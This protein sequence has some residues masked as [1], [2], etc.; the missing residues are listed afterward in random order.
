MQKLGIYTGIG[1]SNS[2]EERLE[3]IKAAGFQVV[4]LNFEKDMEHTET[5]WENQMRLAQK[6]SLPVEAVHL[7]GTKMT[8]IWKDCEEAEF[9]TVR[10]MDEIKAM[11]EVGVSTGVAH[12]TWGFNK[13][14]D[15][16]EGA[17]KRFERITE[18][19]EKYGI[20]IA[21]ENSVFAEHVHYVLDNLKSQYIGFCY[22]SGHENAF[23]PM[24]N[25][26][27]KYGG[28]LF[29]MHLH[30]NGGSYDDHNIPFRGTINWR[31]KV[32]LL[33]KTRLFRDSIILEI[34]VQK[35]S[36]SEVIRMSYEA[37]VKLAGM[38]CDEAL[39]G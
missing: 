9:V 15:P 39:D 25:Y 24:E 7:T 1:Y 10:L 37:A 36:L 8:S 23:T 34:G 19:A 11:K 38:A 13:P 22:D 18:A 2:L 6:Y 30:D 32:R 20:R 5:S 3:L 28:R 21:L 33:K 35:E 4:C 29:A 27:E 12:V 14:A 16:S 17:L 26:L 31:E